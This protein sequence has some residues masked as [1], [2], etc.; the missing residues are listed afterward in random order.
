[1]KHVLDLLSA[2]FDGGAEEDVGDVNSA[3]VL[4]PD[5][6]ATVP[7]V[8]PDTRLR[9]RERATVSTSVSQ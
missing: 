5:V 6:R 1:M 4:E 3:V 9:Q 2:E 8:S 7:P